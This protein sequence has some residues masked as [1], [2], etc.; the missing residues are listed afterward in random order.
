MRLIVITIL[1]AIVPVLAEETFDLTPRYEQG[2][3]FFA[4]EVQE[5]E[6]R[7][8]SIPGGS[9]A[10]TT[11]T[12][13]RETVISKSQDGSMDVQMVILRSQT[14]PP[15]AMPMPF[16]FSSL[17]NVPI[18]VRLSARGEVLEVVTPEQLPEESV[19]AFKSLK[20]MYLNYGNM[21][22]CPDR[23]VALDEVWENDVPMS[24][25]MPGG[26]VDQIYVVRQK[27]TGTEQHDG[28]PAIV[29]ELDGEFSGTISRGA[30]GTI[31]GSAKGKRYLAP[32][33][34]IDR[35][36]NLAIK[37]RQN[38]I[39]MEGEMTVEVDIQY[40]KTISSKDPVR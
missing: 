26:L 34:G 33:T 14:E 4:Q 17:E 6:V 9:F 29:I 38:L 30:S 16:N 10:Y 15:S 21:A 7:S 35:F 24:L 22:Y 36:L 32:E 28:Q 39:T 40:R 19:P 1:L 27:V 23:Q 25:D 18:V 37:Q 12:D 13:Y 31:E 8:S 11:K 20:Q 5:V 2:D 3:V